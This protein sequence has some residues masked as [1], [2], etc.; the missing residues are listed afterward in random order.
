MINKN[1]QINIVGNK[2]STTSSSENNYSLSNFTHFTTTQQMNG[3]R[4][5]DSLISYYVTQE[6]KDE[7]PMVDRSIHSITSPNTKNKR[8]AVVALGNPDTVKRPKV[9]SK[10]GLPEPIRTYRL[11]VDH[12]KQ[13][14]YT[15]AIQIYEKNSAMF[16]CIDNL[17]PIKQV[18]LYYQLGITYCHQK[19]YNKAEE[20][21]EACL[22]RPQY[23]TM[24]SCN[25]LGNL[26]YHAGI[27]YY[28]QRQYINAGQY[29][30]FCLDFPEFV[31]ALELCEKG[32]L[33]DYLGHAYYSQSFYSE[34]K[35]NFELCINNVTYMDNLTSA[36]KVEIY[37]IASICC[38]RCNDL[39]GAL[40]YASISLDYSVKVPSNDP[41]L[42]SLAGAYEYYEAELDVEVEMRHFV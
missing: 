8:S 1:K 11:I 23:G 30:K 41:I 4:A 10:D 39:L 25:Q 14:M 18:N 31:N 32:I 33:N 24:L 3:G 16:Q 19:N 22:R 20:M 9:I 38:H 26:Y 15:E 12:S 42:N 27:T 29:L 7:T 2:Q 34:A 13:G 37:H 40:D 35:Q 36:K 28:C 17:E 6:S 21:F 5:G